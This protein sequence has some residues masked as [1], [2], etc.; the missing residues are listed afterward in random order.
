MV[1]VLLAIIYISFISLGLPDSLLG[2]AWPSMYGQ[3]GVPVSFA[4]IISMIIAAG[5]IISSLFSDSL[6]KKLGTGK[7]TAISVCMTAAALFGFS[8]SDSFILLCI[9][10]IPY[11]LGAG[12]VDAAL[13][14]FVALHYKAKH[15]SWLHCFW[16]V[17]VTAG[18]YIMGYCLTGNKT[19]N[20]GY[21]IV[22]FL[23]IILTAILFFSLPVWKAANVVES[24]NVKKYKSVKIVN[25]MNL[26]GARPAFTA[27]FCYCSVEQTAGLWGASY[28]VMNRGVSVEKAAELASLFYLGITVGRF[29]SG[30]I[31]MKLSD[32]NMIRWGQGIILLGISLLLLPMG[33]MVMYI[34][35]ILIGLGCAPIFPSLL[36]ETPENFGADLSQG[37]M[38]VQMACAYIGTTFM[39]T[40]FGVLA[41]HVSIKLYPFYL[42]IIVMLMIIMVE[43][44]NRVHCENK[45]CDEKNK[46]IKNQVML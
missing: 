20:S 4:G 13:N 2:S 41:E 11:G 6:I 19:W 34:G 26:Q 16:G 30:F 44:L 21:S 5:T 10:S 3:L 46:M 25:L 37:I 24:E 9:W 14:N 45:Y 43:K 38:G 35:F 40:I 29:I 8:S 12:S 31:T 28:M 22:A 36:H 23:Q 39:P 7:L 42:L 18:P 27:F 17:G 1:M 32:K 33:N 15:M